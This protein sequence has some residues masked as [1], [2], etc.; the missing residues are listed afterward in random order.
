MSFLLISYPTLSQHDVDW[1]QS[2]RE[3]HNPHFGIVRP[4]F[5]L[6]FQ[7]SRLGL[8][9]FSG[10]IRRQTEGVTR[11][12]FSLRFAT[13]VQDPG[14]GSSN[15]FLV[16]EEGFDSVVGLHDILYKGQMASEL[17]LDLPFVP[18]ITVG[19]NADAQVCHQLVD[20]LNGQQFCMTGAI[21]S[22]VTVS[23]NSS[24]VT[25]LES[26]ALI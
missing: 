11:I 8:D 4:H 17:R 16:P 14:A 2:V 26:F 23:Y 19:G 24:G 25:D 15:V 3:R 5:T 10:H 6:V 22:V 1:I 7:Q 21:E 13:S 18:H 12:E 9:E 20:E